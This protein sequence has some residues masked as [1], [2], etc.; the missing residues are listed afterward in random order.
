MVNDSAAREGE[1]R[2]AEEETSLLAEGVAST[3]LTS[4]GDEDE[5]ED[6]EDDDGISASDDDSSWIARAARARAENNY[7]GTRAPRVRKI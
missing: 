5:D 6:E 1:L 2:R 7:L 3:E 4:L